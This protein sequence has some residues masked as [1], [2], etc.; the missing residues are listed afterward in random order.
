MKRNKAI[1]MNLL[2]AVTVVIM[3]LG[4]FFIVFSVLNEISF[5]VMKADLH[6]AIMGMLVFYLGLRY[7]LMVLKL[8]PEIYKTSAKFSWSNFNRDKKKKM[9]FRI[10]K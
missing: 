3:F 9:L 1:I 7:Y 2:T 8:K 6:G 10:M 4:L 5:K